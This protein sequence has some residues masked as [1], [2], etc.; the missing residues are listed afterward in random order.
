MIQGKHV[1]F[2]KN[3]D[4]KMSQLCDVFQFLPTSFFP[5]DL[6]EFTTKIF[7]AFHKS[8]SKVSC[9]WKCNPQ[10]EQKIVN[11]NFP[12]FTGKIFSLSL[13][14]KM[15]KNVIESSANICFQL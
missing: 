4:K 2:Y 13:N 7:F 5:G 6:D 10:Q 9:P 1:F 12:V 14:P 3:L 11:P 8:F 15:T